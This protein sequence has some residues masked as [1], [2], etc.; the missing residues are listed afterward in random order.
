MTDA[1]TEVLA[2][3]R[4]ALADTG[5]ATPGSV[6]RDYRTA[7]GGNDLP[8]LFAERVADYRAVVHRV[9]PAEVAQTVSAALARRAAATVV[10][11]EGFPV[12]WL[13]ELSGLRVLR[14]TGPLSL[15]ELDSADGVLTTAAVGIA[16]TGTLVLDAGDGQGRRVLSLVPDYHLCVIRADQVVGGVPEG[17]ALLDPLRPLTF[18]SG[19]SATSD[20]ELNRVEGVHG[21][22]TLEVVLV[23]GRPDDGAD[24][25]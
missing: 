21:P 15:A 12:E 5:P 9:G 11:P 14:D 4:R 17:V 7:A 22:R 2:R 8:A 23:G 19:P 20:I 13:P 16:E 1:R 25:G 6:R 24:G 10:V 3:I 18:I